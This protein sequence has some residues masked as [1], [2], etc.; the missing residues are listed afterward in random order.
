MRSPPK[1][2]VFPLNTDAYEGKTGPIQNR[3]WSKRKN[4]GCMFMPSNNPIQTINFSRKQRHG[5]HCDPLA[6]GRYSGKQVAPQGNLLL[7]EIFKTFISVFVN[8]II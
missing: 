4:T 5:C 7:K 3:L 2:N 8:L 1:G 6:W